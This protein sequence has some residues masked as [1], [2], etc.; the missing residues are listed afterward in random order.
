AQQLPAL[1]KS[2][3]LYS[4]LSLLLIPPAKKNVP[5][6]IVPSARQQIECPARKSAAPANSFCS[7]RFPQASSARTFPPCA[8]AR[9]L[10][11]P[12]AHI[13]PR[14]LLPSPCPL[15]GPRSCP[16]AHQ[17][18]SRA[19]RRSADSILSSSQG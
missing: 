17:C 15:A 18:S 16:P 12:S 9:P 10:R 3:L 2:H 11:F 6:S 14:R 7:P 19:G 4:P 8:P 1:I 13:D 5:P